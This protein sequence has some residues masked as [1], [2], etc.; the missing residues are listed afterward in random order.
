MKGSIRTK[1][2][3]AAYLRD[4]FRC[5]ECRSMVGLEAHHKVPRL[6]ELSNLITLCHACHKKQHDMAG[7]FKNGDDPKRVINQE[8]RANFQKGHMFLGNKKVH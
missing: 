7:C 8:F 3:S 1:L 4:G 5:V 2:D 6:E